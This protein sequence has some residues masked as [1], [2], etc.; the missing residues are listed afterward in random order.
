MNRYARLFRRLSITISILTKC[1]SNCI[2]NRRFLCNHQNSNHCEK[3]LE[4]G[5]Q[6]HVV[7]VVVVVVRAKKTKRCEAVDGRP[8]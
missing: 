1:I 6:K 4:S 5:S 8:D 7:V 3:E 2:R